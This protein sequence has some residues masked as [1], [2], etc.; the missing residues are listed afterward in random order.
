[1]STSSVIPELLRSITTLSLLSSAVC[2]RFKS[3]F[4]RSSIKPDKKNYYCAPPTKNYHDL[5]V[6]VPGIFRQSVEGPVVFLAPLSSSSLSYSR[7]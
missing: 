2:F 7:A 6:L 3:D 1:M 4:R 5:Q